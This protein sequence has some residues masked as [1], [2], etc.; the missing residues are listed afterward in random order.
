MNEVDTE[1]YLMLSGIQHIAFCERQ[2][3]LIH[4]EKVWAEN[5]RTF[6]GHLMH[7][8]ADDPYFTESRGTLL[9]CRSVPLCSHTLQL[10]GIADVVEFISDDINGVQIKGWKGRW[11]PVP[12]EYKYG[13]PKEH[14]A[15][16]LQLCAQAICLEE[17]FEIEVP[18]GHIYYGKTRHR[19]EVEFNGELR[20]K[21]YFFAQ[22]MRDYAE[23]GFTPKPELKSNCR[24]CSLVNLCVPEISKRGLVKG[25]IKRTVRNDD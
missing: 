10:N 11:S 3:A 5:T 22:K 20:Q 24:N 12:V 9:I 6:G 7:E 21:V 13:K 19:I 4:V 18:L 17:I 15:D 25:Y 8:R 23:K 16:K 14:D 2:W 1:N